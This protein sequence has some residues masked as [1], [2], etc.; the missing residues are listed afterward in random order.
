ML[1]DV[2]VVFPRSDSGDNS[3]TVDGNTGDRHVPASSPSDLE[4]STRHRTPRRNNLTAWQNN[5]DELVLAVA[6]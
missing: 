6:A 5:G 4:Y 2:A 3:N 1:Q